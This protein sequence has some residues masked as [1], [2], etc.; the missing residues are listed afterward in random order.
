MRKPWGG[1]HVI[2]IGDPAQLPPV[3]RKDFFSTRLWAQFSVLLLKEVKRASDPLLC[4]VLAK[5]RVGQ[6][7]EEVTETAPPGEGYFQHSAV[8]DCGSL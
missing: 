7:D 5:L 4:S 3:H 8:Q 2:L 1:R 6:C